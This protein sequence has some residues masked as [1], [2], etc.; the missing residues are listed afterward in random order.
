M[1]DFHSKGFKE[2]KYEAKAFHYNNDILQKQWVKENKPKLLIRLLRTEA[3]DFPLPPA[4][5]AVHIRFFP[6]SDMC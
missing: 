3:Q 4:C 6:F 1:T 2:N 5:Q